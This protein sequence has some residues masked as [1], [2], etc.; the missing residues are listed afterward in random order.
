MKRYPAFVTG[1]AL[2]GLVAIA[3]SAT[4]SREKSP[5]DE[6]RVLTDRTEAHLTPIFSAYE[7]ATHVSI[8]TVYLDKGL[9]SRLES[10]PTEADVVITR[11]ADLLEIA[12]QKTLLQ[13]HA[14]EL[15]NRAVPA[16][17]RDPDGMYFTDSYRARVIFYSKDRV[18]PEELSTYEALGDPKWKGRVCIR[19]GYHDY[20]LSLFGQMAAVSGTERTRK[21]LEALAA[22]LARAPAG[23]DRA[24]ARAIFEKKCDVAI[25]NSYYM[26]V[27]LSTPEQRDW[28]LA[29]RVFFPDQDGGGTFI[30]RSGMA[31]TKATLNVKAATA[32][33]EHMVQEDVQASFA[34]LTFSYPVNSRQ[35]MPDINRS[36][37]VGQP[38]VKEG[39]FKIH[40]VRL[41][42]IARQRDTILRM[43]DEIQFDRPR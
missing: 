5:G 29:T 34:N 17:F 6:I 1:A 15:I 43:L 32:L 41:P 12:K 22:N 14:S 39:V 38:G 10:R 28:G 33:L 8:K 20:N 27:M 25:A 18:R 2:T 36:L 4:C 31:L 37:G 16:E 40:A 3:S 24:Q 35:P 23:D 13:S 9:I 26:G 11:D 42:D 19:S 21:F 30:L 7:Q